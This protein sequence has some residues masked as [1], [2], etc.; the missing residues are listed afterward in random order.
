MG[1]EQGLQGALPA[2]GEQ[3]ATSE[4]SQRPSPKLIWR[5]FDSQLLDFYENHL[6]F[7]GR[8]DAGE[9]VV[10]ASAQEDN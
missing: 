1:S 8:D 2:Q 10:D 4:S 7:Q 6:R 5:A 3:Q 9:A